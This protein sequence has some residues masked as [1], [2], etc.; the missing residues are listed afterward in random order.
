MK[1]LVQLALAFSLFWAP[2]MAQ[3][4][5]TYD[6]EDGLM[7]EGFTLINAD[8][9]IPANESD[10]AFIDSAWIVFES[11]LLNSWAALSLS[12]Y[13]ND[14]GPADDW[15]ILP[16]LTL[17]DGAVLSW[18]AQSTTSSGNF[19]DSYQVL[20]NTGEPTY[21]DFSDN[22][23]VLLTVAPEEYQTA[24][25]REIDLS[26][27]A[28][29]SVHLAFRNITPSGDALLVDDIS[30]SN[31]IMTNTLEV[32]NAYF[33]LTVLSNPVSQGRAQ[34]AYT[35]PEAAEV[36]LMVQDL[37]GRTLQMLPLGKQ[38]PGRNIAEVSTA[39]LP[40]GAYLIRIRTKDKAGTARMV[41]R[42]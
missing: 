23:E 36:S 10:S 17:G 13:V 9:L 34:V 16:K 30:I 2:A 40:A 7:P 39:Q 28:G 5:V 35:L 4:T 26:A 6:F 32:D 15:M 1:R 37:M 25:S 11:G 29:Q 42:R 14:A 20:L 19:P 12:W 27:Y 38:Y 3:E 21:D 24:Q 31:V 18:K 8:M 41:V 33:G 22:G